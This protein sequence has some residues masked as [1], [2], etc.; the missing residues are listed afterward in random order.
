MRRSGVMKKNKLFFYVLSVVIFVYQSV[1]FS[2][3]PGGGDDEKKLREKEEQLVCKTQQK[4]V[5]LHKYFLKELKNTQ[6]G[7]AL[8]KREKAS[9]ERFKIEKKLRAMEAEEGELSEDVQDRIKELTSKVDVGEK[10][11]ETAENEIEKITKE[12]LERREEVQGRV[13][14]LTA[15]LEAA[16]KNEEMAEK[17]V[18]EFPDEKKK[19]AR[20][21]QEKYQKKLGKV[22]VKAVLNQKTL[23]KGKKLSGDEKNDIKEEGRKQLVR[24]RDER[25]HE[26][27]QRPRK[28]RKIDTQH[29]EEK[30]INGYTSRFTLQRKKKEV[31]YQMKRMSKV[32]GEKPLD[33]K[34]ER[35][36][37]NQERTVV[38]KSRK[39]RA[40]EREGAAMR[41]L[42]SE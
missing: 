23:E 33:E 4:K 34:K 32:V 28:R 39:E 2:C 26:V 22:R 10:D 41:R 21:V 20:M 27:D 31:N 7:K 3:I 25:E 30:K 42:F 12:E 14:K 11:E 38:Q 13:K 15:K 24:E 18:E 17:E 37:P 16:K 6:Y 36:I 1:L 8:L 9:E 19:S 5:D 35:R 40:A 29:V